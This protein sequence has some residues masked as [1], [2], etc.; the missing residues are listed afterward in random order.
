MSGVNN[1]LTARRAA[2]GTT[3]RL[4]TWGIAGFVAL[5]CT[6][7]IGL[8]T[9]RIIAQ[10]D[11]L[12]AG[13]RKDTANLTS[14]LIQHAELIFRSADAVL[15]AMVERLE[16]DDLNAGMR[17]RIR[18]W[19]GKELQ[20]SPQ[21]V[22]FSA[23]DSTGR[24]F[25]ST[26][27]EKDAPQLSDREYFS[28]HRD[29]DEK[30]I[31]ISAPFH[32]RSGWF[33]PVTRRINNA[34]GTFAGVAI[35]SIDP[36]YFQNLYDRLEL[37]ENSA[38][39]LVTTSGSGTL[40]VRR[41][42]IE[43]NIG[44]DMA[45][46]VI[47][48]QLKQARSGSIEIKASI[49]G[50]RRFNS[51]EQAHAYP[52]AVAVAQNVDELLAPW[53]L[54]AIHQMIEV[55][56]VATF[57][58]V[59]GALV[60]RAT[61][62]LAGRS[63]KLR[64][65]N[66]WFDA[67]L[68]TMPTALSMFDANGK[69]LV[70]NARY[71]ELYDLPR[72]LVKR[73]TS[74]AAIVGHRKVTGNLDADVDAYIGE[75]RQGLLDTGSNTNV[76]RLGDGRVVSITN[77]AT[78]DGG[79]VAIHE[80]ITERIGDE[81]A[82]FK[83]ATELAR[84][85]LRF[86]TALSHMTQG[87]SMYDEHKRLVVWNQRYAELYQIPP[88]LLA[89]GTPLDII[90]N[91]RM[92]RGVLKGDTRPLAVKERVADLVGL[93][94]DAQWIDELSDGRFLLLTRQPMDGGGWLTIVEDI[95]ER[96]RA[97]AEIVHLAR[98][99]V[100]T[101]LANRAQFNEK[102]D[103]AGKRLKRG[104][105]AITVM[106][107]DLDRFKAVNDTLGHAAGD[108][109]LVEVGR[110]LQ[111]R[112][113]ETDLLARLGGD[114]FAIIQEGGDTQHEGAIALALRI[115]Q[116]IAEPFDL[117]GVEASVGASIGIAMAPEHGT[118]PEQLLRN[119]DLALYDA[120]ANGRNDFR[121]YDASMLESATTQ[122]SAES[123]LRDAVAHEQFELH[124][125]PVVNIATREICGVEALV[126]WKHPTKGLISPDQ[127]IPLAESTGLIVPIGEWILQRACN[128]AAAW[129]AHVSLAVNISAVQF[130][131]GNLFDVI[132]CALVDSGLAPDRLE[133]EMTETSLLDNQ[134]AHLATIRQLKNLGISMALDDFGTGYSSLSYLTN[135]PF[136]K[137]KIDR[138]FTRDVLQRRD[139]AAVVSSVLA[140]AQGLGT[141]TTVEGIETEQQLEYMRKAGVDLAQGYLFSQPVPASE[142]DLTKRYSS[143]GQE[144]GGQ[145]MVA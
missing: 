22:S 74:I 10:R 35:A 20:I 60:W 28:Y 140:L 64:E 4:A 114:E 89:I 112:I 135:F 88:E 139:Y 8:E 131:K 61:K 41:P 39:V 30:T 1:L 27:G 126:R 67:A 14:S 38:V 63:T 143:G 111:S 98:H 75:F 124:Y 96:R 45:K 87:L 66:A 58:L 121:I 82:L 5:A 95:T 55:A 73:G 125:Q 130:K 50:V 116:A 76:T 72:K 16:H 2:N 97:E 53:R 24:I 37:S 90:V 36:Q 128:D 68:A 132:L 122:Q 11:D 142:L 21:F 120:K 49:D 51:F 26:K 133:L 56:V 31:H 129:P 113:R 78:A 9:S 118:D 123:E 3:H 42:F 12:L 43:A 71:L 25:I 105:A 40:L 138:T 32:G 85:N 115:I 86:D 7:L 91:D 80:D 19:F 81:E 62:S 92:A 48:T 77:T 141:V 110:R 6:A 33:I 46:S 18:S 57:I 52:I 104:R 103:E 65:T 101:G 34:D 59:M 23:A 99:D 107:I 29:R 69:L 94:P 106:M 136:D 144:T 13:S 102:L 17:D 145:G 70:W 93:A 100:L 127:F 79:W 84:T 134:E 117:G 15:T 119:A 47:L 109:L 44:R 54:N 108:A 137:I 83:Q